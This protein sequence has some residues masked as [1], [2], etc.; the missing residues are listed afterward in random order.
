[1]KIA[2]IGGGASG[3]WAANQIKRRHL[4]AQ[5]IIYEKSDKT[6]RKILSSGNGRG[7]ISNIHAEPSFYN[8]PEFVGPILHYFSPDDFIKSCHDLGV[9][10]KIDEAGRVYP[11]GDSALIFLE[12]LKLSNL[13]FGVIEK[14]STCVEHIDLKDHHFVINQELFDIVII[15]IGSQAGVPL[16]YQSEHHLSWIEKLEHHY[17]KPMPTLSSIGVK[18]TLKLISGQRVASSASLIINNKFILTRKGEVLFREKALSG[19][20]IF[21]LSS[22][23]AW[24]QRNQKIQQAII[25]LDLLPHLS[26]EEVEQLL[27]NQPLHLHQGDFERILT[28]IF[29]PYI[30]NYLSYKIDSIPALAQKIKKLQFHVDFTFTP[31]NQQVMHGGVKLDEIDK[32]S[33]ESTKHENLYFI[34]E[35]LDIDGECGGFNLHFAWSSATYV[36]EAI[37]KKRAL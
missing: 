14:L 20:V 1:M 30:A 2:I 33:L 3:L 27:T 4:D 23:L 36:A 19:I 17:E 7:N 37:M 15:A 12:A 11:Y 35:A 18:E 26:I 8:N 21:E 31:D 24:V 22:H 34:G 10:T 29:H 13:H 16:K 9:M 5:V 32:S 28:G 25:E 6:G